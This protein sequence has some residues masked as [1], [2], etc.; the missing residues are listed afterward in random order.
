MTGRTVGH[1]LLTRIDDAGRPA[2]FQGNNSGKQLTDNTLF[3]AE[4]AADPGLDHTDSGFGNLQSI[5][6]NPAG[7]ERHLGRADHRQTAVFIDIGEGAE[8]LHHGLT[9]GLGVEGALDHHVTGFEHFIH[10]PN[11]HPLCAAQVPLV[12]G[13]YRAQGAEI[14]LGMNEDGVVLGFGK[15]Q[16][17]LHD[18]ILDL[19][20]PQSLVGCLLI[21]GGHNGYRIT[22][23]TQMTVENQPVI[24]AGLGVSLSG[25]SETGVGHILPGEDTT[26]AGH[27][28][29][30]GGVDRFDIRVGMRA[31]QELNHQRILGNQV[32]GIDGFTGDKA[33]G[34]FFTDGRIDKAHD[35]TS[36][37]CAR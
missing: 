25:R 36:C 23:A 7:V 12:I 27:F 9:V 18:V 31:A 13:S 6:E 37:L 20:Q 34:V 1:A 24:G 10:V 11:V 19:N 16:Q 5:G 15:V 33:H 32:A 3:C 17:R 28:Q 14:V 35:C 29:C 8:C 30:G 22:V 4:A 21:F 26:H 2:C